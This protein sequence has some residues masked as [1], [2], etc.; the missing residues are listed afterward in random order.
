MQVR[1]AGGPLPPLVEVPTQAHPQDQGAPRCQACCHRSTPQVHGG[2]R[3]PSRAPGDRS[4]ER[5]LAAGPRPAAAQ[6]PSVLHRWQL[7]AAKVAGGASCSLGSGWPEWRRVVES[8]GALPRAADHWSGR[9][10][11]DHPRAAWSYPGHD[12]HGL[13]RRPEAVPRH[14]KRHHLPRGPCKMHERRLVG[15]GRPSVPSRSGR[16][17]GCPAT[18]RPR[19][20]LQYK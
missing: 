14:P 7:F 19:R 20:Q 16:C 4:V 10:G 3:H 5:E 18:A 12:P 13:P 8:V 15:P 2:A 1:G 9:V 6:Q 11:G 17:F